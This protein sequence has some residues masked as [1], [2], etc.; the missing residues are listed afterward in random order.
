MTILFAAMFKFLPDAKIEWND[1]WVGAV[2]TAT[3]FLLGK[4]AIALYVGNQGMEDSYGAAGSLVV[5]LMWVYY[6][7]LIFLFGAEFTQAWAKQRGRGIV[8]DQGAVRIVKRVET[9]T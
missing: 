2:A 5:I 6:S 8:P 3:L 1:V 7:A 9:V 4:V